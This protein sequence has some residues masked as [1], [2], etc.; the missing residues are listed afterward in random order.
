[1]TLWTSRK[2]KWDTTGYLCNIFNERLVLSDDQAGPFNLMLRYAD[3]QKGPPNSAGSSIWRK[4]KE[5]SKERKREEG[6]R[7]KEKRKRKRKREKELDASVNGLS[8]DYSSINFRPKDF[9]NW[10]AH[11]IPGKNSEVGAFADFERTKIV[12]SERCVGRINGHS[13]NRVSNRLMY[14]RH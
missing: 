6:K 2:R 3:I 11:D 8:V 1:M 12:F 13:L 10:D 14:L 5:R 4:S 7:K 9:L